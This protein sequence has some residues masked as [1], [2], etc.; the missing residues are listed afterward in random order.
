M[1]KPG[2]EKRFGVTGTQGAAK[3]AQRHALHRE[4]RESRREQFGFL[5]PPGMT[6]PLP[7]CVEEETLTLGAR[8]YDKA[9]VSKHKG[10]QNRKERRKRPYESSW[11]A[12]DGEFTDDDRSPSRDRQGQDRHGSG[13][14]K[15]CP[16]DTPYTTYKTA[17]SKRMSTT[18]RRDRRR[19]P[20]NTSW[21]SE[22]EEC[23][24]D[25]SSSRSRPR[26]ERHG[27]D[28]EKSS[29]IASPTPTA[30]PSGEEKRRLSPP[31]IALTL[32][33]VAPPPQYKAKEAAGASKEYAVVHRNQSTNPNVCHDDTGSIKRPCSTFE[34]S[35]ESRRQDGKGNKRRISYTEYMNRSR[36]GDSRNVTSSAPTVQTG[37]KVPDETEKSPTSDR[38]V[39]KA[40]R[41]MSQH[42]LAEVS[43]QIRAR[44]E[45]LCPLITEKKTTA[46]TS[47]PTSPQP[48]L[49]HSSATRC[50]G[51]A[52]VSA[53]APTQ[54]ETPAVSTDGKS[55]GV[56]HGRDVITQ[57]STSSRSS[58][59]K[60][61][62]EF[63]K[64]EEEKIRRDQ[65][66]RKLFRKKAAALAAKIGGD[67]A[68]RSSRPPVAAELQEKSVRSESSKRPDGRLRHNLGQS[69]MPPSDQETDSRPPAQLYPV[70]QQLIQPSND[71]Q[72]SKEKLCISSY[73]LLMKIVTSNISEK[74]GKFQHVVRGLALYS[75]GILC[76]MLWA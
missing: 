66:L 37:T 38:R 69:G 33:R 58:I 63:L 27:S 57:K 31:P 42:E 70:Q 74:D 10:A 35:D 41:R 73:H 52:D 1:P 59:G 53:A 71:S 43:S 17:V 29:R 21:L 30:V 22:D 67:G 20:Y 68:S 46:T 16:S 4:E 49:S 64:R 47:H 6:L 45:A 61:L 56:R 9:V 44:K 60:T 24:D 15:S 40:R 34:D 36:S 7:Q 18:K 14:L 54:E 8:P 11:R 12:G 48:E 65:K 72:V 13:Q 51:S 55:A 50:C 26:Q 25:R 3:S 19:Q 75:Y 39:I 23:E 5:L 32:C 62:V 76:Y 28:Q 2:K